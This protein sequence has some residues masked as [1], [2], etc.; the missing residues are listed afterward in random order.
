MSL[1]SSEYDNVELAAAFQQRHLRSAI[2]VKHP[3]ELQ[4][5]VCRQH[6]RHHA[7]GIS[8]LYKQHPCRSASALLSYSFTAAAASTSTFSLHIRDGFSFSG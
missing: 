1:D 6:R 5:L 3:F 7:H 8:S 4:R 2:H